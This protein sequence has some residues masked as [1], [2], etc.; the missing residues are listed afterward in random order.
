MT[1][2]TTT[3]ASKVSEAENKNVNDQLLERGPDIQTLGATAFDDL[4]ASDEVVAAFALRIRECTGL[5]GATLE[6]I[7]LDSPGNTDPSAECDEQGA[8]AVVAAE[9]L[10]RGDA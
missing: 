5:L 4:L 1:Q 6:D 7:T 10:L 2:M 3:V 8:A 9:E